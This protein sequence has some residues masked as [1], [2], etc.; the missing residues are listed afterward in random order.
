[1]L[2]VL[3]FVEGIFAID[4]LARISLEHHPSSVRFLPSTST[5]SLVPVVFHLTAVKIL[6]ETEGKFPRG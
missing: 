1:L 3:S 5:L 2:A 6:K 4:I